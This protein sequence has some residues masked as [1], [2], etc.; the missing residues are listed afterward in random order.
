MYFSSISFFIDMILEPPIY[1]NKF[2]I[3]T[4]L[5]STIVTSTLAQHHEQEQEKEHANDP[6]SLEFWGQIIAIVCLITL[7]GVVAGLTLGLMSLDTTN[8][9]ILEIAGTAQ[10]QHYASRIIP[11]RKNGHILLSTLLLTNTVLNETLPILFD[12]I[13][14]K[15][16]IS[17]I[18]STALLVLFSEI[19]PQ[20]VFSKHGLAIGAFL[21]MPVRFLIAIWFIIAWPIAKFLDYVLGK[22]TGFSY[23]ATGIYPSISIECLPIFIYKIYLELRALISLH[24]KSKHERGSLTHETSILV[25]NALY[26]QDTYAYQMAKPLK[27]MLSLP[28][29]AYINSSIVLEYIEDHF[30]HILVYDET[31]NENEILGVLELKTLV[32]LESSEYMNPVGKMRLNPCIKASSDT[33]IIE[34][35]TQL[36]SKDNEAQIA[37]IYHSEIKQDEKPLLH[38]VSLPSVKSHESNRISCFIKRMFSGTCHPC[39]SAEETEKKTIDSAEQG[40]NDSTIDAG[41]EPGLLGIITITEVLNQ[42]TRGHQFREIE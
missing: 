23:N 8:L 7:S 18:L 39:Q 25:Q 5:L 24:D 14:S 29:G 42:L 17:I 31:K 36:L 12:G 26:M 38:T 33:S 35:L 13:F 20:A 16:F 11:I 22:H 27:N 10:Q 3:Y 34:L 32:G 41:L 21:A 4:L 30:T 2:I 19:I 9:S 28:I 37:F 40:T 15:G 6:K 1:S